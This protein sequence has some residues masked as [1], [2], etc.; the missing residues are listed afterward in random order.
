MYH[1]LLK[2]HKLD[3]TAERN[4]ALGPKDEWLSRLELTRSGRLLRNHL[5]C[6]EKRLDTCG[7]Q[8]ERGS[9]QEAICWRRAFCKALNDAVA[10]KVRFDFP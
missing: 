8:G 10:N 9:I 6:V 5:S 3:A 4:Q 1:S 7:R 2:S